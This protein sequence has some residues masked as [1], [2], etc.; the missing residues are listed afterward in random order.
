MKSE[1]EYFA[2]SDF[3]EENSKAINNYFNI[4]YQSLKGEKVPYADVVS[5]AK[6]LF[7]LVLREFMGSPQH[8]EI[9][10][11]AVSRYV[12]E[13]GVKTYD[14]DFIDVKKEQEYWLYKEKDN[15]PHPFFDRYRMYLSNDGF[16][17]KVI[18]NI[19]KTCEQI[20]ARCA[21]PKTPLSEEKKKGLVV[22]DV[23]SGKTANYLGLINMAYDY[24][25][26]IVILLAGMTNSLREQTQ[27][28]TDK[29]VIGA[30]SDTIGNSIEFVGVGLNTGEHFA[31]PFTNVQNDFKKFVQKNWNLAISDLKKPVVLVVKKNKG[32]LESVAER[33]QSE[34]TQKGMTDS[35]SILIIDDEADNASVS[36]SKDPD[37]PTAINRCIRDIFNKF[38]VASYVGYTATPFAN[39]FI[40]PYDENGKYLD[41]FPSDFI[42]QLY[43][44]SIYFG[45]R[46]VFPKEGHS[47][48]IREIFEN[49]KDFLP[50]IHRK[51]VEYPALAE[52]LKDAINC[53]L[54]SNVIRT[55]RGDVHKHRSMMINITRFNDPQMLIW[56][57]VT[58]YVKRLSEAIEQLSDL[59]VEDFVKNRYCN[60]L[61]LLYQ[62]EFFKECREG[63][64]EYGFEPLEWMNIQAGLYSEIKQFNVVVINSRNG[65]M[66]QIDTVGTSKRFN[67]D[68][69][70]NEGA[71]VI[72]IGGMVLSRGLTLEGLMT[73][74][75]SRN[76]GAYDTLLQMC[77]W[78]GYRPKYKD[79]CRI[80]LT[81]D[82][83]DKFD[84]VLTAT[85]DLKE[86]FREM[87]L[88]DKKPKDFGLMVKE[89]PDT[90]ET[91]L[92]ITARNKLRNTKELLIGLN[93]SGVYA[94][95]S[96]MQ[97]DR[98]VNDRNLVAFSEF[99][100][101]LS[102]EWYDSEG[103]IVNGDSQKRRFYLAR[104]VS[105][106][107]IA[108]FL[109]SISVPIENKKFNADG[110]AEYV[111]EDSKFP[112]WDVLIA[113]G[114]SSANAFYGV[115]PVERS[116]HMKNKNDLIRIGGQNNR[117]LDPG[118]FDAG[119]WLN[120]KES[121]SANEYLEKRDKPILVVFPIDLKIPEAEINSSVPEIK[122]EA[123][124]K[125]EAKSGLGGKVL[126]TFAFGFPNTES[127][128]MV[129]YRA[130][131]V[132][133]EQLTK[134]V[135]IDDENEGVEDSDD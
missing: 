50:V 127:K 37:K 22:G 27:K 53:F 115:K 85:E 69:Y 84:A 48:Y 94:D 121:L 61:F 111:E 47:K 63:T 71:R 62:S 4:L 73:S 131:A 20:L 72:A 86:Q 36:T 101:N 77:R 3:F 5:Q 68:D 93:Y 83:I 17:Q 59:P 125:E 119:L 43:S 7:P 126:L 32:I 80:Y 46:A 54:I 110:L 74:Y 117:V 122:E 42:A 49:E 9:I 67:Y 97:T 8:S 23:Q 78:F 52:S 130:N 39:I 118:Q 107:H 2:M 21:N 108:H 96:K 34:L 10:K 18:D 44:P 102:F 75:Y 109:K 129:K 30:K 1:G 66:R 134:N 6:S 56:E 16:E 82:N 60:A 95:T 38:P 11:N 128:I 45:G 135:E 124:W 19:E 98:S 41:L 113:R 99:H 106:Y 88:R 116:F 70:E 81:Q 12:T 26:K 13:V 103:N 87:K 133:L 14:P 105:Q 51:D 58:E 91:T 15:I 31:I 89:S 29:G 28:R 132:K 123:E 35:N 33:L 90:L 112:Y 24:G 25:Y 120:S 57:K 100:S 40:N 114:S 104:N 79:L 65:Q 64:T 92:L 55:I 76:A